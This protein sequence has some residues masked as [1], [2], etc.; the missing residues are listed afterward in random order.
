MA[1][2]KRKAPAGEPCEG[3]T[4]HRDPSFASL[5]STGLQKETLDRN[6]SDVSASMCGED[7]KVKRARASSN[8]TAKSNDA[9]EEEAEED[10][11]LEVVDVVGE[12]GGKKEKA[13]KVKKIFLRILRKVMDVPQD[14]PLLR[15]WRD[16]RV[17]KKSGKH[18][19]AGWYGIEVMDVEEVDATL[20]K[21]L[22]NIPPVTVGNQDPRT[23]MAAILQID[24]SMADD[25][26]VLKKGRY[27]LN[28]GRLSPEARLRVTHLRSEA[29]RLHVEMMLAQSQNPTVAAT[30]NVT[31]QQNTQAQYQSSY[32]QPHP[33][34]HQPPHT[35]THNVQSLPTNH[36]SPA[37]AQSDPT[38][39]NSGAHQHPVLKCLD[40]TRIIPCSCPLANRLAVFPNC[41][42]HEALLINKLG[43][44]FQLLW[45]L[46]NP[47]PMDALEELT[48]RVCK[49][50][51]YA[52][53][54]VEQGGTNVTLHL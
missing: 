48:R 42:Y 17:A 50:M 27:R 4:I 52:V 7:S 38:Y 37:P 14:S 22:P 10:V 11:L 30:G 54:S 21:L 1:S 19:P 32:S 9:T 35:I 29:K 24:Q 25:Y 36:N 51:H 45:E 43:E 46:S 26:I 6:G 28:E 2:A 44:T 13:V 53:E 49:V 39:H 3:G 23:T 16:S 47:L 8:R 5:L 40:C 12:G 41:V 15:V 20:L 31:F 33:E 34:P 18:I